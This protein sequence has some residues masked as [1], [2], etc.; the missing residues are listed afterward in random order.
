MQYR[1][2]MKAWKTHICEANYNFEKHNIFLALVHYHKAIQLAESLL[3]LPDN[4]NEAVAAVVE[5]YQNLA[6][7]YV[8]EHQNKLAESELRKVY[9]KLSARLSESSP[10]TPEV[11]A[12]QWGI[13]KTYTALMNQLKNH[14]NQSTNPVPDAFWTP[15]VGIQYDSV[16]PNINPA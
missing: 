14:P 12:L 4:P 9:Q 13:G 11:E 5:S 16:P 6:N 1:Q 15:R 3:S 10:E 2:E 7:L 8:K